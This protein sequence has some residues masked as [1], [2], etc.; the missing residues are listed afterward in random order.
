MSDRS[1]KRILVLDDETHIG[2]L[3]KEYLTREGFAVDVF[4]S[5]EPAYDA[6]T[7]TC[8]DLFLLD[9][10]MP[11]LDGD[12]F[13]EMVEMHIREK[14]RSADEAVKLPPFIVVTGFDWSPDSDRIQR[15]IE[16]AEFVINKPFDLEDLREKILTVFQKLT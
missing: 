5:P 4:N 8:Y 7:E 14:A 9:F 11:A 13:Y 3:F 2:S 1:D 6:I 16:K 10:S 15:F 12:R